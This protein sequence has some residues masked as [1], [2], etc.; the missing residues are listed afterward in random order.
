MKLPSSPIDL[1]VV[2][3]PI[4]SIT[5]EKD[6]SFAMMLEAQRHGWR[7]RVAELGDIWIR[8]GRA[9]GRLTEVQVTDHLF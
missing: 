6:S 7:I 3:D 5:P 9:W 2:M 4:A 8:D 1:L